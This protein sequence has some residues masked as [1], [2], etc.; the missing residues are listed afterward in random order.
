VRE[1]GKVCLLDVDVQG[2]ERVREE[3]LSNAVFIWIAPPSMEALEARLRE[4]QTEDEAAIR[5]RL[6]N[7][8]KELSRVNSTETFDITIVNDDFDQAYEKLKTLL[9]PLFEGT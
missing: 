1:S 3:N 6:S 5:Q 2:A 4:R 8:L 9:E 7:S